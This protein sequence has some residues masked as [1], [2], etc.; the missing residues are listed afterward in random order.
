[1]RLLSYAV[2]GRETYGVLTASDGIVELGG[3]LKEH[4]PTLRHLVADPSLVDLKKMA[5][6][7][8]DHKLSEVKVLPVIGDPAH[9]WCL[10]INYEDHIAEIKAVG[11]QRDRPKFPALFMRYADTLIADGDPIVVPSVSSDLDWEGELAVVIGR[12]GRYISEESAMSHVAG[13]ACFNDAS[14]RDWQ[15]HTRQ[16]AP[17]KNFTAS[18]ALGPWMVTADE[19][20]DPHNLSV[21]TWL[22]GNLMQDGRTSDMIFGIP[23]FIAY[24]S[25]I[26]PLKPGDILATGTPSGVGF[27]RKPPIYMKPG[28]RCVIE[29][30][31]VG[32]LENPVTAEAKALNRR[33]AAG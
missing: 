16:I 26:S 13:Y 28:D 25:S 30:E 31:G 18:G 2:D 3:R 5:A 29:V 1:M 22:N 4:A 24:V 23:A 15:F 33:L 20:P 10:A 12:G 6:S 9:I 14:I 17:G 21:K 7:A 8:A 32:R 19:I 11:I 27:S